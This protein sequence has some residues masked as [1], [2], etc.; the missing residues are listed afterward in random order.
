MCYRV[1]V[2]DEYKR[3]KSKLLR[4]TLLFSLILAIILVADT[5]LIILT[6]GDYRVSLS[7]SII[8]TILFSWFAIY[9]FTNIY[10]DINAYY[11]YFKSFNSGVKAT[12]EVEVI[13]IDDALTLVNGLYVYPIYIKSFNGLDVTEKTVY[14]LDKN[15]KFLVGCKYT[16]VTYQRI[17]I[18]ADNHL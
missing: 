3:S 7:I 14:T 15:Y 11:R 2:E 6:K 9:F 5:L 18:E 1:D 4:Y 10:G 17:V 13:K 8:I 16:F 12:E